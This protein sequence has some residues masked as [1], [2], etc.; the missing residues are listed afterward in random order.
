MALDKQWLSEDNIERCAGLS[1]EQFE[2]EYERRGRP[3]ILTDVVPQ[4]PAFT[5]WTDVRH[6][7]DTT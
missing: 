2:N 3:V 7:S 6:Y 5:T 1:I 4:W